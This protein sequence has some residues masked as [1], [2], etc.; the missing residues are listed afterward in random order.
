M[1]VALADLELHLVAQD[2]GVYSV[3]LRFRHAAAAVDAHLIP[4]VPPTVA[5]DQ[6]A[7]YEVA[8]DPDVYGQ[9]LTAMLFA[10]ERLRTAFLMARS[11]AEGAGEALR[12]CLRLDV[13]D[14][15]LH[16]LRWETLYDPLHGGRLFTSGRVI[17]SR[18]VDSADLTPIELRA[19]RQLRALVVVAAPTDAEVYGL[20]TIKVADELSR[21]R[22]ALGPVNYAT[23]AREQTRSP[24][25]L[26]AIGQAMRDGADVLYLVAHGKLVEGGSFLCLEGPDGQA[27]WT[28][29]PQLVEQIAQLPRRPLLIVLASCQ[30]AGQS[31]DQGALAALGPA[32]AGCGVAAVVAM[33]GDVSLETVAALTPALLRTFLQSGQIDLAMSAA[34]AAVLQQPDW[35]MPVLFLRVRSGQILQQPYASEAHLTGP[36]QGAVARMVEDYAAIFGGRDRE[37]EALDAWLDRDP[38]PY[39]FLHAPTGR[40]KTALLLHWAARIQQRGVWVVIVV[41]ISLRYQ[42]ASAES[43]LGALAAALANLHGESERRSIYFGS[44]DQ[45]RLAIADYLRRPLGSGMR[46]LLILDGL[47]EAQGWHVGRELF[48]A[49]PGPHLRVVA[50]ARERAQMT[51]TDWYE[52]LGWQEGQTVDLN[53]GALR[54]DAMRAILR[55]AGG[56]LPA[57]SGDVRVLD[58]VARVSEG[59]PLTVHFLVAALRDGTLAPGGLVGL[60]PGLEAYVRAW[61]KELEQQ[62]SQADAVAAVLSL[63]AVAL[64]P[65]TSEDLQRL[66]PEHLRRR[67]TLNQ[68][69]EQVGRFIIGDGSAVSGYVFSHPRLREIFVERVLSEDERRELLQRF[70]ADGQTLYE[71]RVRPLPAYVRRFWVS[72]L[73]EISAW[74]QVERVLTEFVAGDAHS[75]QPWAAARV[76]V[77]GNYAGYLQDLNLLWDHAEAVTDVVLATRC[78]LIAASITSLSLG[79]QSELLVALV[80]AGTPE[81]R[82]SIEAAL[83]HVQQIWSPEEQ[84]EALD[85]LIASGAVIP[86]AQA[87]GVAR[88]IGDEWSRATALAHLAP[89]LPAELLP[90]ALDAAMDVTYPGSRVDVLVQ[91]IPRLPAEEQPA[92]YRVARE[93]ALAT[94]EAWHRA[95]V[96]AQLAPHLLAE[97]RPACFQAALEAARAIRDGSRLADETTL[98]DVLPQ[99]ALHLPAD[100]Q[101]ATLDI[102]QKIE[103]DGRRAVVLARIASCLPAGEQSAVYQD[104]MEVVLT[105]DNHSERASTI[106]ELLPLL[107]DELRP[108]MLEAALALPG[109]ADVP[110]VLARVA[111]FLP[112]ED[113]PAVFRKAVETARLVADADERAWTLYT[114]ATYLPEEDQVAVF[115]AALETARAI[116]SE[117]SRGRLLAALA[118]KLPADERP[119]IVQAALETT[120]AIRDELRQ[121][122]FLV[123]LA[124]HVPADDQPGL[125]QSALDIVHTLVSEGR[126]AIILARLA[127]YMPPEDQISVARA[128]LQVALDVQDELRRAGILAEIAQYL[129]PVLLPTLLE[130][131]RTVRDGYRRSALL[132][133]VALRLSPELLYTAVEIAL[134]IKEEWERDP[135]LCQLIPGLPEDAHPAALNIVRHV[136]AEEYR[137]E[138]L[139]ALVPHLRADLLPVVVQIAHSLQPGAPRAEVLA[140]L[141]PHLSAEEQVAAC[142]VVLEEATAALEIVHR[143]PA[144][145]D[146][147]RIL[148]NLVPHLRADLLPVAVE[149][150]HR[151]QL[152][153]PRVEVLAAL[154]PHLSVEERLAAYREILAEAVATEPWWSRADRLHE[155]APLLPVPLQPDA[156]EA[157][158][159]LD[160]AWGRTRALLALAPHLP[161]EAQRAAYEAALEAAGAVESGGSRATFLASIAPHLPPERRA[162]IYEA[163]L[164]AACSDEGKAS[165]QTTSAVEYE[166]APSSAL[167]ALAPHLAAQGFPARYWF[168]ALRASARRGRTDFLGDLA[169]LIPW[170]VTL[171][172]IEERARTAGSVIDVSRY[173]L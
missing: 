16:A 114:I 172:T 124:P 29:G 70:V 18:Y 171:T 82:W 131:A 95:R 159:A 68:A 39:A 25:T 24:V 55:Q 105:I 50:S 26:A 97:E 167:A 46:L 103:D 94:P 2:P 151:L 80:T 146:W 99:I 127:P 84:V 7:L 93:A 85:A 111:T 59:D 8:Q 86:Y 115:Q 90:M 118:L 165:A 145:E 12:V 56:P 153:A 148:V 40:G 23:L 76:A 110:P 47:D 150:A 123:Q 58:E 52:Q 109:L 157:I 139:A 78:A 137:A 173:W 163:A 71:R 168:P 64:G 113:R 128:A 138:V 69:V 155:L 104:S 37:L 88:S 22:T 122:T 28:P 67:A 49:E 166:E 87:L 140:A 152:G 79:M 62:S 19:P 169:A 6:A 136:L 44:P 117:W 54:R 107:P 164:E 83:W 144:E 34:R 51:R 27:A 33:Q 32:L 1:A 132:S 158:L 96:L 120:R 130:V 10:D 81:G 63:C 133:Q 135:L 3:W 106:V 92:L 53:L 42:T 73:A 60:T 45:L 125:I 149:I 129:P 35:W 11:E 31:H 102:A 89:R 112:A 14:E 141:V 21:A 61:Y 17:L 72:H 5:I 57:V 154:V 143:V 134:S 15:G 101:L 116:E 4:G 75:E 20:A 126:K 36:F 77:E 142:R 100:L 91:L 13:Q 162:A 119:P 170:L 108:V 121:V 9:R 161:V 147:A 156:Y 43:A 48:P 38:R 98:T 66:A 41:P 65:L 30:S 74:S 160:D